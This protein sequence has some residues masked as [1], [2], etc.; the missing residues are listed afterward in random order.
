MLRWRIWPVERAAQARNHTLRSNKVALN[1]YRL[2]VD[3]F[4]CRAIRPIRCRRHRGVDKR[5]LAGVI[6]GCWWPS[7]RKVMEAKVPVVQSHSRVPIISIDGADIST[8]FEHGL[9]IGLLLL[10][11]QHFSLTVIKSYRITLK[12]SF[13]IWINRISYLISDLAKTI[14]TIATLKIC[15]LTRF[16]YLFL[17]VNEKRCTH[18][19][20]F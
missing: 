15:G 16:I 20:T 3:G 12:R 11:F 17:T 13:C 5:I 2:H 14:S 6:S 10:L 1:R 8:Y 4:M 7:L 19:R 18:I 9:I